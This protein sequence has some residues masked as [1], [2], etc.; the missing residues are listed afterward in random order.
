M[1]KQQRTIGILILQI[2]L[3]VYFIVTGL[4]LFGKGSSIS[5]T[6]IVQVM[7]FFGD[8]A[9][10]IKPIFGVILILGGVLFLIKTFFDRLGKIDDI[11]KYIILIVWIIVTVVALIYYAKV[12]FNGSWD[13]LHWCLSLA[14]NCLI[15]GGILTIKNGQ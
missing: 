3:A 13:W 4:C 1:A 2:A 12:D 5:S 9:K 15:I 8:A 11:F 6:E 10:V 7:K 14:K